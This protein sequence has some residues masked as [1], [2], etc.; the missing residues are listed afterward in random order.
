MYVLIKSNLMGEAKGPA[1]YIPMSIKVQQP[2]HN[3]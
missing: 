2:A 1:H 3:Q